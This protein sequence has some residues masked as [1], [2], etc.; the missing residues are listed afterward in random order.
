MMIFSGQMMQVEGPEETSLWG[1]LN[2]K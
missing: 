1:C 2:M